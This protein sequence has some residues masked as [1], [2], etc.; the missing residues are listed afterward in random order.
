MAIRGGA[1]TQDWLEHS[2]AEG[3]PLAVKPRDALVEHYLLEIK[4]F[5][6]SPKIAG[7]FAQIAILFSI[8]AKR[9]LKHVSLY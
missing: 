5:N 6:I 7:N 3:Q 8:R 9:A 1:C 2:F 4:S